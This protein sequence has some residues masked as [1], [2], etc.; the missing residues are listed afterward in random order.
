MKWRVASLGFVAFAIACSDHSMM[1]DDK[2]APG[3]P[4][5][6]GCLQDVDCGTGLSC[7][8]FQCVAED[9]YLPEEEEA[10]AF[11]RPAASGRYVFALSPNADSLAIIDPL[12]LVIEAVR[13]P[14]NPVA[15]AVVSG[16]DRVVVVSKEGRRVSVVDVDEGRTTLHSVATPRRFPAIALSPDGRYA[17]LWT[18]DGELP[19]AGAEGIIALVDVA[20]L[21]R[22][23]SVQVVEF[24]AGRR[25]TNV[26]FRESEGVSVEAVILGQRELVI[27]PL[28][29]DPTPVR[30][31]LGDDYTELTGRE[32]LAPPGGQSVLVRSIASPK[33]A[34]FNVEGR[35]FSDIELPAV[36]SDLDLTKDGLHAVAV[37]RATS[38]IMRFPLASP[39]EAMLIDVA[40]PATDCT[41]P[42]TPCVVAPGQAVLT[43]DGKGAAV[44]TNARK[45]ESFGWVDFDT[46]DF[47]AFSEL[48]KLVRTIGISPAGTHAIVL[49][50]ADPTSTVSDSY[51]RLV[52]RSEGYSIVDLGSDAAQLK[53]TDQVAPVEFVWAADGRHAA[54]TLRNDGG[55]TY[56]VDA[57]DLERLV[58]ASLDLASAPEYAGPLPG[59]SADARV[60]VTQEHSA[61]RISFVDLAKRTVRTATGYELNAEIE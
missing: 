56:R 59:G 50:R 43:P 36:A 61:G 21:G 42:V 24:A 1:S 58:V 13:L 28:A 6:R 15:L 35:S 18:P 23:E 2:D 40:L 48:Q 60:W 7:L 12:S 31:R 55:R 25:H 16:Q 8:N 32:A 29:E 38:Q 9:G 20:A 4:S 14:P 39:D 11:L 41:P 33:L 52:D 3:S 44:F 49:H 53:L 26:F 34:V 45:S 10:H 27:L 17:V 19:D 5:E 51:E 37:L 54:V 30:V 46:G 22:G 57:I 47:R